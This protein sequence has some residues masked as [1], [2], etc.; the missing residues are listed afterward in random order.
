MSTTTTPAKVTK[1]RRTKG[2]LATKLKVGDVIVNT[3]VG[4]DGKIKVTLETVLE[5][6]SNELGAE[7]MTVRTGWSFGEDRDGDSLMSFD[8]YDYLPVL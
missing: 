4:S 2:K 6:I 5:I 8:R 3:F 1:V 7:K